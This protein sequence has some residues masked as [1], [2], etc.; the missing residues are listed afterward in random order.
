[1]GLSDDLS[2]GAGGVPGT[3]RLRAWQQPSEL[4]RAIAAIHIR[5]ARLPPE[6]Q[7]MSGV[8]APP[9]T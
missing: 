5:G 4:N 2:S 6:V 8:E 1:M 7:A 9:K 3:Y